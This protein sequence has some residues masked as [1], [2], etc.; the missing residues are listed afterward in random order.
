MSSQ[1][2]WGITIRVPE[3]SCTSEVQT[4]QWFWGNQISWKFDL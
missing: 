2:V 1:E 4:Y 3:L